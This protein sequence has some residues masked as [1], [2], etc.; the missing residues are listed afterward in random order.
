MRRNE[1]EPCAQVASIPELGEGAVCHSADK[2]EGGAR[3]SEYLRS[4]LE[5]AGGLRMLIEAK[6]RGELADDTA[7]EREIS[8]IEA[9][10]SHVLHLIERAPA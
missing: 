2:F 10:V 4:A 8:R 1:A 7:I 3:P 6:D 5:Y 9:S